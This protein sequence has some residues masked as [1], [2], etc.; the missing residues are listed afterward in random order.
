VFPGGCFFAAA[1]AQLAAQPGRARDRVMAMHQQW[2]NLFIDALH[3]AIDEGTLPRNTY[4]EQT[5]FEITA[6][7]LRANFTWIVT[8]DA[9]ALDQ[10]RAGIRHVFERVGGS[11]KQKGRSAKPQKGSRSSRRGA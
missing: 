8:G 5:V 3:Q 7:L 6:M 4:L 9:G 10:A 2:Q 11:A 1:A